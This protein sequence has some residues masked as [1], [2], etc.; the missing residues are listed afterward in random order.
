MGCAMNKTILP[1]ALLALAG[2]V[3]QKP[4]L[5]RPYVAARIESPKPAAAF[6]S[7]VGDAMDLQVREQ[8]GVLHIIRSRGGVQVARW[9]FVASNNGSQAELRTGANDDAGIDLVRACA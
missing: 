3:V 5:N 2:C 4:A 1:L 6:S 9:D 8:N 7:C